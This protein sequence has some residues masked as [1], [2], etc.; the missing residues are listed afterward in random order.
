LIPHT[1][2]IQYNPYAGK[3]IDYGSESINTV[4]SQT[5]SSIANNNEGFK[6]TSYANDKDYAYSDVIDGSSISIF[7]SIPNTSN[8]QNNNQ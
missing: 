2:E 5:T 7:N 4:S 8:N 1:T 3:P 6:S